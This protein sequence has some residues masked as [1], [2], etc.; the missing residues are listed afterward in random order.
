[1]VPRDLVV[2]MDAPK[3][4]SV[5]GPRRAG[6]TW[7]LYSLGMR[8]FQTPFPSAFA[9]R[10]YGVTSFAGKESLSSPLSPETSDSARKT[11]L[12]PS[13]NGMKVISASR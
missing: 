6:K 9:L 1:M 8:F 10:G 7:Y 3:V 4:V 13:W 5:I 11:S 12:I 2:P